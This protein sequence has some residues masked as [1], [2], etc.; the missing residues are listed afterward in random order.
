MVISLSLHVCIR[1]I[2]HLIPMPHDRLPTLILVHWGFLRTLEDRLPTNGLGLGKAIGGWQFI[3]F[4]YLTQTKGS[5]KESPVLPK[6]G[7][8]AVMSR[9]TPMNILRQH[10]GECDA[11]RGH[12]LPQVTWSNHSVDVMLAHSCMNP[13]WWL[14]FRFHRCI[15]YHA[16]RC[17]TAFIYTAA[18]AKQNILRMIV[19]KVINFQIVKTVLNCNDKL[20]FDKLISVYKWFL[21]FL[22]PGG[23]VK[24]LFKP[25]LSDALW[26]FFKQGIICLSWSGGAWTPFFTSQRF[27]DMRFWDTTKTRTEMAMLV[28]LQTVS[29]CISSW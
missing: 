1:F 20:T 14:W 3:G 25:P 21:Y 22:H 29:N 4:L 28:A 11:L 23:V 16:N 26:G 6:D 24:V 8:D 5:P 15:L 12:I 13:H 9:F 17:W 7:L 19:R 27:H 10:I 2:F 18:A